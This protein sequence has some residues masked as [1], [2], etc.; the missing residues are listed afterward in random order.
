MTKIAVMAAYCL[1][2]AIGFP[3]QPIRAEIFIHGGSKSTWSLKDD[4]TEPGAQWKS[5][6]FDDS[7]WRR[8]G[9]PF[10]FGEDGIVTEVSPGGGEGAVRTTTYFRTTFEVRSPE[11]FTHLLLTVC[12]D[13][14]YVAYLNGEE[15]HRWNMPEGQ[16][17][18]NSYA[19]QWRSVPIEQL[20]QR[21]ILSTE[22]LVGG[23]NVLAIELHQGGKD[24]SDLYLDL[25]L[26]GHS[27]KAGERPLIP[28]DARQVT[29]LFND[30]HYV[31]PNTRIPN[32]FLDGG[33]SMQVDEFGY[34]ISG[35]EIMLV[36]RWNDDR[37][38]D[39]LRYA[40]SE[41]IQTLNEVDRATRIARYVDR[42]FTP[43]EGRSE[44][45]D[46]TRQYLDRRYPSQVVL[47]GDIP[48]LCGAG[49]CRH[50][51]LLFKL[52][53]DEAGLKAALVR[54]KLGSDEATAGGH[55]W[56]ELV[57]QTG[58]KV[59][60]DVMNPQPDFYFPEVGELSLRGYRTVA[61]QPKYPPAK[62]WRDETPSAAKSR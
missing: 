18:P 16:V 37:L 23:S 41:K 61:N 10:G 7:Q 43:P 31:S 9:G 24:S 29:R 48:L 49:V 12:A 52:M 39:H 11:A 51:S 6:S 17:S 62:R 21:F 45:V 14:G 58:K 57:L 53:A 19:A 54:G 28:A 56:N 47:L 35:R 1:F 4:G 40:L 2:F 25:V 44:C 50:R 34:V 5:P 3:V 38:K 32:G 8:G 20:Y 27:K 33:R 46:R 36:D 60:V 30:S 42:I 13:D 26:T 55:A 59:I 22:H 15:L